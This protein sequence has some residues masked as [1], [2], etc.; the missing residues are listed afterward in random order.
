MVVATR[1]VYDFDETS[2][3]GKELLGGKGVGLAEMTALG[4]PVPA[5]FTVTTDACRAY[6]TGGG[7]LPDGLEEEVDR[8]LAALEEK[9]GKRFGDAADPLLVSVRPAAA[10]SMPGVMDTIPNLGLN[11]V[12]GYG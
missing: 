9:S 2:E 8:P 10:V 1:F 5:G 4:V 12:E 7:E 6:M 3:G 11:D